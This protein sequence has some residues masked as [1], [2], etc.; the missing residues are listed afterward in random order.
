MRA[1][2]RSQ[3][4]RSSKRRLIT[5]TVMQRVPV[6]QEQERQRRRTSRQVLVDP[7]R[8]SQFLLAGE[9]LFAT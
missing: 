1:Q 9:G 6:V 3:G 2:R 5:M 8:R 4:K 7:K